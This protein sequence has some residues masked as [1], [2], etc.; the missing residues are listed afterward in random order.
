MLH[1]ILKS[2]TSRRYNTCEV[3]WMVYKYYVDVI[4]KIDK[5]GR[6]YPLSI[7]WENKV[8]KIDKILSMQEKMSLTG[9]CGICFECRFGKQIRHL[10]W[11][12]DKWFLETG[13]FCP[14]KS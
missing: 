5:N 13:I 10:Y 11:E 4:T 14:D 12:K 1:N 8:Y 7:C 2:A 6:L 9:G 3:R